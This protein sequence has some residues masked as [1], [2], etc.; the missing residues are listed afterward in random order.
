MADRIRLGTATLTR[1]LETTFE[2][3]DAMFPNTPEA[4]WADNADLLVPTFYDPPT[5]RCRVAMQTWVVQVDGLTVVIDT[6]V[7]NDRERP[8]F[9]VMQH[10]STGF[11]GALQTA[12]IKPEDVDVVVNT[13]LHT[14][15]V[16]W[17]THRLNGSWLPTFPNAR[18]LMPDADYRH[19]AP[20]G[21]GSTD[22]T[23]IV[24]SDSILPVADQTEL[25][26]GD[27]QLSDS[28]WLRP[29]AGHTPGSTVVWLDAGVPAVF[30]GDLTHCP[31]QIPRPGDACAFDVDA[32][33]AAVTRKRIFT[34][35]ARR[36]AAVVPA[37]YPGAGGATLVARGDR[38]EVDDWLELPP[39]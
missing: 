16:G 19:F 25:I 18:Y 4:A 32:D 2:F 13:H 1:V 30:V 27:Y 29:A 17:N 15:H 38:F 39:I 12:G 23:R 33:E 34:E 11:L 21:P 14:D 9:A 36:R 20:D 10:L 35:A 6:G 37:H 28:L 8:N 7:G 5:R 24:F 3:G 22:A 31:I 26:A